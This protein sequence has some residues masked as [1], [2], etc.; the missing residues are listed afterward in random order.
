M[1][2][3]LLPLQGADTIHQITQGVALGY[4][5]L[6]L[7]GVLKSSFTTKLKFERRIEVSSVP[8][9]LL[10]YAKKMPIFFCNS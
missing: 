3:T 10:M 5:L 9:V 4:G 1:K 2:K 6:P 7:P 8:I